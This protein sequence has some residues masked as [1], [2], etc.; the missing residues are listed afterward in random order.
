MGLFGAGV[1]VTLD[2][3]MYNFCILRRRRE[4]VIDSAGLPLQTFGENSSDE[5]EIITRTAGILCDLN[6]LQI[7][8]W[9]GTCE[10]C[11]D[12]TLIEAKLSRKIDIAKETE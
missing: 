9:T 5:D 2:R 12:G 3:I 4:S 6:D 10:A 1:L 7:K 8:C 11:K